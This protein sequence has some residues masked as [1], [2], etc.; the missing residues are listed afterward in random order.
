MTQESH[1]IH[2]TAQTEQER[3]ALMNRLVNHRALTELTLSGGERILDVGCGLAGLTRAMA[4]AV[5]PTGR[6]VGIER[7]SEQL[8]EALRQADAEGEAN[9]VE[10]RRGDVAELP[11]TSEEWGSFD[12]VHARFLLEHLRRPQQA[13]RAMV[14]A[15]RPGG[16]VVLQDDDHALL[17]LWPEPTGFGAIWEAYCR[18]YDRA[19][20]DP[21]IGRRLIAL[22][23]DAGARPT[24]NTF[25]FFG[26]S[27]GE[28]LF[29]TWAENCRRVLLSAATFIRDE[30]LCDDSTWT[31]G[32]AG[33]DA[34]RERPDAAAWY[35]VCW[36]EGLRPE[37]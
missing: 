26:A 30:A 24:R 37:E 6:V 35:P 10:L 9:L 21:F 32:L 23:H 20:N 18:S 15:V 22:L 13:V 25:L 33:F 4:R 2:G 34:W 3:L 11:L 29:D 16:R 36:A 28:P 7:N 12:I 27:A 8:A 17:R 14:R 5:G 31:A 19:G 1:Y